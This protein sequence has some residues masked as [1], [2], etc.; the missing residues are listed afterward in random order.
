MAALATLF[1][2]KEQAIKEVKK[3]VECIKEAKDYNS[4]SLGKD[5]QKSIQELNNLIQLALK[6]LNET[7][8]SILYKILSTTQEVKEF[9][10]SWPIFFVKT[11]SLLEK[12]LGIQKATAVLLSEGLLS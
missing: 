7:E 11:K 4:G 8:L 5:G 12:K 6:E 9:L 2:N 3:R 10:P 1:A